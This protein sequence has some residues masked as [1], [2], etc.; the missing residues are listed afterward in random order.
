MQDAFAVALERWPRDGVPANPAA[1]IVTV[2]R[3]RAIDRIRRRAALGRARGWRSSA[4]GGAGRGRRRTPS[5]R[6]PDPRRA[7]AADLHLLPSGARARG[8]RRADPADARRAHDGRGRARVPGLRARDGAAARA[9]EGE[10]PRRGIALRA[11]AR[12]G[13][14][15]AAGGGAGDA[16]P[17]LQRGLRRDGRRRAGPARAVRRGDPPRARAVR[18]D[19]RRAG[20]ARAAGADAP[21]RLA[22]RRPRR[23]PAGALVLLADQD[24]SRWDRAAIAEG[25]D[26]RSSARSRSARPRPLRCCRPSIAAEHAR[27]RAPRTPTGR[28]IAVV[29]ARLRRARPR[30]RWSRSTARSRWRW[31]TARRRASR[32]PTSSPTRSTATT[33]CTPPARTCCAGSAATP[34]PRPPTARAGARGRAGRARLPPRAPRRARANGGIVGSGVRPRIDGIL[35]H[36]STDQLHARGRERALRAAPSPRPPSRGW[37]RPPRRPSP[38]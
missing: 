33:C 17:G 24:R 14:A 29:Y 31:P 11:A 16:L 9:R 12:R 2:A 10:D 8:A 13:P 6:E 32:S 27:R 25:M 5:E 28:A 23:T 35:V 1:W 26:A 4:A 3:N 20:G 34:R 7:A 18:A 36:V 21:A 19:A 37:P 30:A 38:P 15:G 22:P